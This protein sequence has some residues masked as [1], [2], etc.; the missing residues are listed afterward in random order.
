M[1]IYLISSIFFL[2]LLLLLL[3]FSLYF[4][5]K[6]LIRYLYKPYLSAKLTLKSGANSIIIIGTIIITVPGFYISTIK[7]YG[8]AFLLAAGIGTATTTLYMMTSHVPLDDLI[9]Q[10][11]D[12]YSETD[13][14]FSQ[15]NTFITRFHNFVTDT[16]INVVTNVQGELG[17]D[18]PE[19]LDQNLAQQYANRINVFDNLIHNHIHNIENILK[20]VIE[21]EDQMRILDENYQTQSSL[22]NDRLKDLIRLYGHYNDK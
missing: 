6:F 12:T 22:Y 19:N 5:V 9:R 2:S 15:L 4:I 21:L 16:D 8:M 18:V 7:N 11:Q 13:R 17:I 14:L 10:L 3:F 20:R 1:I